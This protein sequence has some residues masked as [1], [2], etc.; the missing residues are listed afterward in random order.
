MKGRDL[1]V[2]CSAS[3]LPQNTE[4]ACQAIWA[5]TAQF[6]QP[7]LGELYSSFYPVA[8]VWGIGLRSYGVLLGREDTDRFMRIL[9]AATEAQSA[10]IDLHISGLL[11]RMDLEQTRRVGNNII[12]PV[13]LDGT[14]K[15]LEAHTLWHIAMASGTFLPDCCIYYLEQ[16]RAVADLELRQKIARSIESYAVCAVRLEMEENHADI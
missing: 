8:S 2:V 10:A 5:K 4:L 13:T 6:L 3:G 15:E 16:E 12:C 14:D 9:L 11:S 7:N 1:V